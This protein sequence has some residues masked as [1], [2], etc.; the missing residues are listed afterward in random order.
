MSNVLSVMLGNTGGFCFVATLDALNTFVRVQASTFR[1]PNFLTI[2][3]S[4]ILAGWNDSERVEH[5]YQ[6][7]LSGYH[8]NDWTVG[9]EQG[10][11]IGG[12]IALTGIGSITLPGTSAAFADGTGGGEQEC[13]R[14]LQRLK[15]LHQAIRERK[16]AHDRSCGK[17]PSSPNGNCEA[18]RR[19][20]GK[21]V[22]WQLTIIWLQLHSLGDLRELRRWQRAEAVRL[23]RLVR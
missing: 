16:T 7:V 6:S 1:I 23:A 17:L 10:K 13:E 2:A 18:S 9:M 3:G 5:S 20:K 4:N 14:C 11:G 19:V 15:R 8:R 22:L 12:T 21:G